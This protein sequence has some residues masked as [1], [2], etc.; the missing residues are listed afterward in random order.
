M[1][2]GSNKIKEIGISNNKLTAISG[3]QIAKAI[4]NDE[5][6]KVLDLAWNL[7]GVRPKDIK[8]PKKPGKKL[9]LMK[10]GE[11]GK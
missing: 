8:H 3:N 11:I 6:L 10:I 5:Q 2:E 7:I 1:L 9:K 4:A